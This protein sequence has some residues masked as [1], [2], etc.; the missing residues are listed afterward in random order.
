M[1]NQEIEGQDQEIEGQI[2][3]LLGAGRWPLPDGRWPG[4]PAP[5]A[6]QFLDL[7][8][9]FLILSSRRQREGGLVGV[10]LDKPCGH[11]LPLASVRKSRIVASRLM[12]ETVLFRCDSEHLEEGC[13]GILQCGCVHCSCSLDRC[14]DHQFSEHCC[15]D[16]RC[17]SKDRESG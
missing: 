6:Q 11:D 8:F 1:K 12:Q 14:S 5:S 7:A 4:A 13:D 15:D 9:D 16:N 3:K 17:A 10:R 2:K